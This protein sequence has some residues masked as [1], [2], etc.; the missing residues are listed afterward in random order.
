M[1]A[2]LDGFDEGV[3]LVDADWEVAATNETARRVLPDD[4]GGRP[5]LDAFPESVEGTFGRRFA[6]REPE[7]V[8]FEEFY[9]ALDAW[10]A[11]RTR[12]IDGDAGGETAGGDA[13]G[14]AEAG[15]VMAVYLRDAT[16]DRERREA[17]AA[18]ERELATVDRLT[19]IVRDVVAA[20]AGSVDRETVER[21]IVDRLADSELYETAVLLDRGGEDDRLAERAAAGAPEGFVGTLLD[22]GRAAESLEAT[23]LADRE[24]AVSRELVGDDRLPQGIR[25]AA[26]AHGLQS[27]IALPLVHDDVLY[28][29]LGV[30]TDRP[31]AFREHERAGF[32]TLVRTAAL[33]IGAAR[34]Q[35]LLLS[36]TVVEL[37]L[38][39][40]GEDPLAAA[41]GRGDCTL[42]VDGVVPTDDGLLCYVSVAEGDPAEAAA[43]LEAT[44]VPPSREI[45]GD[46]ERRFELVVADGA[47]T[48]IAARGA[49]IRTATFEDGTGRVV[50]EVAPDV[51][52]RALVEEIGD[53][54]PGTGLIAKR[55]HER[56]VQTAGEFRRD[57]RERLTDRQYTALK[58][59]RLADYFQ[60]PRG[61]TAE[62][63]A[64][65]LDITS[66][67]LHHHLR[68]AER[69]LLDAFFTDDAV[70]P[71][72]GTDGGR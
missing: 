23:A 15:T 46:G 22:A 10:L 27:G 20:M 9:P 4:P 5:V 25:R 40:G 34:R 44:G 43:A 64:A 51:D 8:S 11:V 31:D 7:A 57:L 38:R 37:T 19:A 61:S 49:T 1:D 55:E 52:V 13:G 18:R 53:D 66:P 63:V 30:Y 32:E 45:E 17:L 41:S 3:I 33:A 67:T 68:A 28:G 60:S 71:A 72:V 16:E 48:A 62:E 6:D 59:A 24:P 39:V 29:V 36:D 56:D 26:F 35:R 65:S 70:T 42:T 47:L 58:T 21:T 14:D 50:A 54:A 69:K 12:P 2:V